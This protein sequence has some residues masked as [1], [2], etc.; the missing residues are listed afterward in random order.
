M[1]LDPCPA[2]KMHSSRGGAKRS[3]D[4]SSTQNMRGQGNENKINPLP[5]MHNVRG[6]DNETIK[7]KFLMQNTRG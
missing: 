7:K 3:P 4:L 2:L 1:D 6:E 5:P